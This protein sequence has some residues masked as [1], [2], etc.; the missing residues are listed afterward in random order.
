MSQPPDVIPTG[1]LQE[2]YH[3]EKYLRDDRRRL[4]LEM[5]LVALV[6][7]FLLAVFALL[8]YNSMLSI[9]TANKYLPPVPVTAKS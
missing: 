3:P 7:L 1:N 9:E 6:F 2:K 4:P 5:I 8:I